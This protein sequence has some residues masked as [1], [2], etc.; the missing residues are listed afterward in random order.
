VALKFID[1]LALLQNMPLA[2]ADMAFRIREMAEK[3]RP[4]HW[5][6]YTPA[7]HAGVGFSPT[8]FARKEIGS[9]G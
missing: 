8:I 6:Y 5:S 1:D 9:A 2:V 7:N 4:V 3:R